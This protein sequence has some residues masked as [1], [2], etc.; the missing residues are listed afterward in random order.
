[1]T[2]FYTED[3]INALID[4]EVDQ[5][6]ANANPRKRPPPD[7]DS[8]DSESESESESDSDS[9]SNEPTAKFARVSAPE[10]TD[11]AFQVEDVET[12][13]PAPVETASIA[14]VPDD[15]LGHVASML[16]FDNS[17]GLREVSKS[18]NK[19]FDPSQTAMRPVMNRDGIAAAKFGFKRMK[20]PRYQH[21]FIGQ[22]QSGK[23]RHIQKCCKFILDQNMI[24][25][26]V[27]RNIKADLD[28]FCDRMPGSGI[29]A[30]AIS[31]VND[32]TGMPDNTVF[33]ALA[34]KASLTKVRNALQKHAAARQFALVVDESDFAYQSSDHDK[35][36]TE[37]GLT[38]L[39]ESSGNVYNFSATQASLLQHLGRNN[40]PHGYTVLPTPATYY[41]YDSM[42]RHETLEAR[43]FPPSM[44][45][46]GNGDYSGTAFGREDFTEEAMTDKPNIH[47]VYGYGRSLDRAWIIHNTDCRKFAQQQ[48]GM[49]VS[50]KFPEFVVL[51]F[52][53]D[54]VTVQAPGQPD[55]EFAT[56]SGALQAYKAS[57]KL[58]I[59]AGHMASRGISF[60]SSDHQAHCNM[61]YLGISS[62]SHGE[63]L[64]QSI[65]LAGI[66]RDNPNLL[67]FA[68]PRLFQALDRQHLQYENP[69]DFYR[70]QAGEGATYRPALYPAPATGGQ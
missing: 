16:G 67:L 41:G 17:L 22:V 2:D 21:V 1:M 38:E 24:P 58:T 57:P 49:Y 46:L 8:D 28:Q 39:V 37:I 10:D 5:A 47:Q 65:R 27:T 42:D 56:L 20:D 31:D 9:D 33:V 3:E 18:F 66:Y 32:R 63:R 61:Q 48:I 4:A 62:R 45:H 15:T 59:I 26:V 30:W 40:V 23:T 55:I 52:N 25:V 54:G 35:A 36:A 7:S 19:T 6:F 34:N 69:P 14:D 68:S 53:G 60:V 29:R 13:H 44:A 12:Q 43:A 50:A 64:L 70:G 51:I 11:I